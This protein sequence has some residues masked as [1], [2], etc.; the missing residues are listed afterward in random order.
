MR[1]DSIRYR[2]IALIGL[3]LAGMAALVTTQVVNINRLIQVQTDATLLLD[4]NTEILQLR[5]HEKDFMLRQEMEYALQFASRAE[6]LEVSLND[7]EKLSDS[8][9]LPSNQLEDMRESLDQYRS[10]FMALT[11]LQVTIGLDENSGLQG[12]LRANAHQLEENLT[13]EQSNGEL[14]LLLQLR[15]LEKDFMQR[16]ELDYSLNAAPVYKSLSAKLSGENQTLLSNYY[17]Q[18]TAL[19]AAYQRIGLNPDAGIQ[20][21]FR[22][23]AHELEVQ[24]ENI[25]QT[26]NPLIRQRERDVKLWGF[27]IATLTVSILLAL[28]IRNFITLQKTL[29]AFLL[30]FH[31]SKREYHL[32]DVK[33]MGFAEF[34]L[35]AQVANEMVNARK[36]MESELKELKERLAEIEAKPQV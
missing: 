14:L 10:Q 33:K 19:V 7:L 13:Q 20:G 31:Q 29:S 3:C 32:I 6:S 36:E 12:R 15:R 16:R 18:F 26:L 22:S 35:L 30:F 21:A 5:R 27:I 8:Y 17:E 1:L 4:L 9:S 28:L 2:L 25:S 34:R 24:L 23:A 11:D